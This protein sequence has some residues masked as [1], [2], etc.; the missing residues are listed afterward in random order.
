MTETKKTVEQAE[1]KKEVTEKP[2]KAAKK[3][4][5]FK[6]AE[7]FGQLSLAKE[8]SKPGKFKREKE[9][10]EL[11]KAMKDAGG[12]KAIKTQTIHHKGKKLIIVEGYPVPKEFTDLFTKEQLKNHFA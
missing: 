11:T 7:R 2:K 1:T 12:L 6:T 8:R 4:I 3:P 5:D 10:A 9:L